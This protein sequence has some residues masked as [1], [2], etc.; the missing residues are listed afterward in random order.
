M[1]EEELIKQQIELSRTLFEM[2]P[3]MAKKVIAAA[4]LEM[5]RLENIRIEANEKFDVALIDMKDGYFNTAERIFGEVADLRKETGEEPEEAL[6]REKQ[7]ECLLRTK[8]MELS[9]EIAIA[10]QKIYKKIGDQEGIARI[11][12]LMKEIGQKQKDKENK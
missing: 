3:I 4:N 9:Q 2:N 5:K 1:T 7:A 11:K 12:A 10:A 8:N 6:A